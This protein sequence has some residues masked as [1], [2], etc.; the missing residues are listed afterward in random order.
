[1]CTCYEKPFKVNYVHTGNVQLSK[2][3]FGS[4]YYEINNKVLIYHEHSYLKQN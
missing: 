4:H 2:N 3:Y 1:M